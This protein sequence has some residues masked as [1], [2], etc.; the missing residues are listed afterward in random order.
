MAAGR[1]PARPSSNWTEMGLQAEGRRRQCRPPQGAPGNQG[2]CAARQRRLRRGVCAGC[3]TWVCVAHDRNRGTRQ[4]GAS[5]PRH[6]VSLP[7]RRSS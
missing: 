1:A 4:L 3:S 7:Q 2:L 6:Q 5:P